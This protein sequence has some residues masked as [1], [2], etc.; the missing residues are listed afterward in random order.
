MKEKDFIKLYFEE[1]YPDKKRYVYKEDF[2][3]LG[4]LFFLFL[5]FL[6]IRAFSR[7]ESSEITKK[8]ENN[9][10]ITEKVIK[11]LEQIKK[12]IID[13]NPN[14]NLKITLNLIDQIDDNLSLLSKT[15]NKEKLVE[16]IINQLIKL[17]EDVTEL[18][19]N[20]TPEKK[21]KLFDELND[22]LKNFG[23]SGRFLE[24]LKEAN[25]KG[26]IKKD[27]TN[28]TVILTP[29]DLKN[30]E[31][32]E[33][34]EE[35]EYQI[36]GEEDEEDEE[37]LTLPD[38]E[39]EEEEQDEEDPR[40]KNKTL[41]QIRTEIVSYKTFVNS[42]KKTYIKESFNYIADH[43]NEYDEMILKKLLISLY[44]SNKIIDDFEDLYDHEIMT[45]A[46][47]QI[48]AE[49]EQR[50]LLS[51]YDKMLLYLKD[52]N[53]YIE[54]YT[55]INRK[56]FL[57]KINIEKYKNGIITPYKKDESFTDCYYLLFKE[58]N[59]TLDIY[60]DKK[61]IDNYILYND[62]FNFILNED[63]TNLSNF[64]IIFSGKWNFDD[65]NK[66]IDLKIKPNENKKFDPINYEDI[67]KINKTYV[68]KQFETIL[69]EIKN[70]KNITLKEEDVYWYCI[71]YDDKNYYI[72]QIEGNFLHYLK[73]VYHKKSFKL[74]RLSFD[75]TINFADKIDLIHLVYM[76]SHVSSNDTN[77]DFI[78]KTSV[79]KQIIPFNDQK[80]KKINPSKIKKGQRLEI[81]KTEEGWLM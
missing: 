31:V 70:T 53:T 6:A 4:G 42:S 45:G 29:D 13:D 76:D 55:G 28:E 52:K 37:E 15:S 59:S 25:K 58:K 73:E 46:L 27:N 79:N 72:K 17:L 65:L 80:F 35:D 23:L 36:S 14:K 20:Q 61:D 67:I 74:D 3:L 77:F 19:S 21:N 63:V 64:D 33:E 51:D 39:D 68:L 47:D 30:F 56:E 34:N 62:F 26:E 49:K 38:E 22:V 60:I 69:K 57:V 18:Y 16:D 43:V 24:L 78:K 48:E 12:I 32:E 44:D 50:A 81:N 9:P 75:S 7:T 40:L 2:S 10:K 8:I 11:N 1:L 71:K 54:E 5:V 66:K 41:D